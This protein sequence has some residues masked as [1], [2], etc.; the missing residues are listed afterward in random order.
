MK[1]KV[2]SFNI[3][4][5]DRGENYLISDRAPRL[6]AVIS[7]L[8]PDAIGLQEYRDPWESH[9]KKQFPDYEMYNAW[10]SDGADRESGPILWKRDK[11]ELLDTGH[12]WFSDTPE[13]MSGKEW[14]EAFQCYRI[15]A[16]VIL[17]DKQS[18]KTFIAM[19]THLGFGDKC[20]VNSAKLIKQY[21][22]KLPDLPMF[23]TGDFNSRPSSPAYTEMTKSFTDVNAA[24]VND[25]RNTYNGFTLD[26]HLDEHI[27]YCFINS[28][29]TPITQK[30][31]DD[32]VDG[33]FP[34]DHYGLYVELDI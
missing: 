16:Y 10:R 15:C 20:Q 30:I 8:D 26:Q 32:L 18:G 6:N 24:T 33:F 21:A 22:D 34:S 25:T 1:L 14:D 23:I 17:K 3:L 4:C 9:I 28:S 12:F 31:I 13:V 5:V 19:N 11:F 7:P 29:V 27:D 2:V